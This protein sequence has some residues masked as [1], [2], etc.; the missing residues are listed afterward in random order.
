MSVKYT[1]DHEWAR[2]E[3]ELVVVGITDFAQ[4]QLGEIVFIE[5]PDLDSVVKR[6]DETA[7]IE[8]VKA[9]GEVKAPVSGKVVEI[10]GALT[11][12]PETVN[13]SPDGAGWFYKLEPSDPAE[14]DLLMDE[15][16]YRKLVASIA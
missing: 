14:L 11:D 1:E 6:G 4:Q 7:V 9:A 3:N 5:L 16:A 8:S 13:E 12:S 15:Q 10:N 2:S